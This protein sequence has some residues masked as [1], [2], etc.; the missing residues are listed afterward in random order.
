ME[1]YGYRKSAYTWSWSH[2]IFQLSSVSG[3]GRL[4]LG[5]W[6]SPWK[7]PAGRRSPLMTAKMDPVACRIL[8][9]S[10]VE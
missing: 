5:V 1:I 8:L 7:D 9:R 10:L 3:P 2:A 6:L 4:G